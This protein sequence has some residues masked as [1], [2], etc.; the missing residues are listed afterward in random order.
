M[1]ALIDFP[2]KG[3][4]V[5]K[6]FRKNQPVER[7]RKEFLLTCSIYRDSRFRY[8]SEA[9]GK[10]DQKECAFSAQIVEDGKLF[11]HQLVFASFSSFD[12]IIKP[13]KPFTFDEQQI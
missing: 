12:L 7:E 13:R 2:I 10:A 5:F 4:T 6:G 8:P 9:V 3:V 1:V 11:C